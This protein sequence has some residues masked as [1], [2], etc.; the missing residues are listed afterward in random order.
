MLNYKRRIW[1]K[2]GES[3]RVGNSLTKSVPVKVIYSF[4][5]FISYFEPR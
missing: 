5:V 4:G 1:R 3:E 2:P